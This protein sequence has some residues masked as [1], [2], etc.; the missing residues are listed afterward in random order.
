MSAGK[1]IFLRNEK[2]RSFKIEV[3]LGVPF[4]VPWS[5]TTC[6]IV[7][8]YESFLSSGGQLLAAP[9]LARTQSTQSLID[10]TAACQL[11]KP[12]VEHLIFGQHPYDLSACCPPNWHPKR[13]Q[14]R[15]ARCWCVRSW[16][17]CC[18]LGGRFGR[19]SC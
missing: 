9:N 19:S 16:R 7:L 18:G 13:L 8:Q 5:N 2:L 1:G 4:A 17:G 14:R 3:A 6:A 11:S 10:A 12:R 15:R